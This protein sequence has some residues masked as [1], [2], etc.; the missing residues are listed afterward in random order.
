MTKCL[1]LGKHPC[2]FLLNV[3]ELIVLHWITKERKNPLFCSADSFRSSASAHLP[4][5]KH[6]VGP[7]GHL[8]R[9]SRHRRSALRSLASSKALKAYDPRTRRG[10][11]EESKG[12]ICERS[13]ACFWR[14]QREESIVSLQKHALADDVVDHPRHSGKDQVAKASSFPGQR[15]ENL[16][17]SRMI[18]LKPVLIF[19]GSSCLVSYKE[20]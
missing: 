20:T 6:H 11:R 13:R 7:S 5:S 17:G 19:I 10:E 15:E 3:V 4:H 2:L 12:N 8:R 1:G 18:A 14:I 9:R 16:F